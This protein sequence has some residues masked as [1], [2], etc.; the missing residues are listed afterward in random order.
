ML[1]L[2]WYCLDVSADATVRSF[3]LPWSSWLIGSTFG[4]QISCSPQGDVSYL[5]VVSDA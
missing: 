2:L 5:S 3:L 1:L 4:Y